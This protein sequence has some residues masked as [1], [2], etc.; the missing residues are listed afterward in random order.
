MPYQCVLDR[1]EGFRCFNPGVAIA[2]CETS[3]TFIGQQDQECPEDWIEIIDGKCILL[4]NNEGSYGEA[5]EACEEIGAMLLE[6]TSNEEEDALTTM[7]NDPPIDFWVGI[8]DL[9]NEGT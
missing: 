8:N 5:V 6:T 4:M 9:A 2:I 7:F 3:P 1:S